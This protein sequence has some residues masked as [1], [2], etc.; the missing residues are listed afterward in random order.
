MTSINNEIDF[1]PENIDLSELTDEEVDTLIS[2][3]RLTVLQDNIPIEC[4][5]CSGDAGCC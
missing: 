1:D 5:G 4:R 2:L 3:I